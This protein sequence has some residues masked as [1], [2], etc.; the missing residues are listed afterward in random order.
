[1]RQRALDPCCTKSPVSGISFRGE[2]RCP[3]KIPN[4]F[5]NTVKRT[6]GLVC[7]ISGASVPLLRTTFPAACLSQAANIQAVASGIRWSPGI[8]GAQ[9]PSRFRQRSYKHLHKA[10]PSPGLCQTGSL[11]CTSSW[12]QTP[13][14]DVAKRGASLLLKQIRRS[15][16]V[17]WRGRLREQAGFSS[18][19]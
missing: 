6:T 4:L 1:M 16:F 10:Q 14:W 12:C 13:H 15:G 17:L 2:Q 5:H 9:F 11:A 19:M 3:S 8:T 7:C 18:E